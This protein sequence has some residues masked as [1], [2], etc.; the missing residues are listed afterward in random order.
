MEVLSSRM[1]LRLVLCK[2]TDFSKERDSP[3]YTLKTEAISFSETSVKFYQTSRCHIPEGIFL[4]S[5]HHEN[6]ISYV[7]TAVCEPF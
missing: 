2:V 6:A 5:D 3:F 4:H 1:L 7:L